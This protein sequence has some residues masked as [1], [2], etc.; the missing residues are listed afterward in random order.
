MRT[1]L[2]I[3]IEKYCLQPSPRRRAVHG[4]AAVGV[5]VPQARWWSLCVSGLLCHCP[6]PVRSQA[7]ITPHTHSPACWA[8]GLWWSAVLRSVRNGAGGTPISRV[9]PTHTECQAALMHACPSPLSWRPQGA[10]AVSCEGHRVF[11]LPGV[12]EFPSTKEEAA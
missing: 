2:K 9:P 7:A 3:K 6:S 1:E 11:H 8:P 4:L 12:C 10:A 5:G